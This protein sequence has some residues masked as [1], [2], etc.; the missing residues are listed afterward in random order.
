VPG[1]WLAAISSA[2]LFAAAH[3]FGRGGEPWDGYVFSFRSLA[4]MY[5]A[6]LFH[7]R[8]F[9]IAVGA[10]AGYDVLVGLLLR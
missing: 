6:A 2:V 8:G 7:L 4:G 10:H 1:A 9:G 3:H 5:F